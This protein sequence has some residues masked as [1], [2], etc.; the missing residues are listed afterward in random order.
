M[1]HAISASISRAL[2]PAS[3]VPAGP[4]RWAARGF[5]LQAPALGLLGS[6]RCALL[7]LRRA[8]SRDHK[9]DE[10]E[11]SDGSWTV[12]AERQGCG[13]VQRVCKFNTLSGPHVCRARKLTDEQRS[14]IASYFA[15][16]KGQEK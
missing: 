13:K 16:Y 7:G 15:V 6:P 5:W 10:L 9:I 4:G 14:A 8:V 2:I 11:E 1:R 12:A 3:A